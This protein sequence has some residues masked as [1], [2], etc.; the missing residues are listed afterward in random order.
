MNH[1][2]G[3]FLYSSILYENFQDEILPYE[4][5]SVHEYCYVVITLWFCLIILQ[6]YL[7]WPRLI[8]SCYSHWLLW[9]IICCVLVVHNTD[10]GLDHP[11]PL[12]SQ[13]GDNGWNVNDLVGLGQS[14]GVV[15]GNVGT[16]PA[17]TGTEGKQKIVSMSS[18]T[19]SGSCP[20]KW[21]PCSERI[22]D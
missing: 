14:E 17:D 20:T 12:L 16:G 3:K 19:V 18:N 7:I 21:K 1:Y 10:Q 15:K 11:H 8:S 2:H 9:K 13:G 4:K 6:F 5:L 22:K